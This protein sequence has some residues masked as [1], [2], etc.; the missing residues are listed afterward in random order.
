MYL[1]GGE[2]GGSTH[3]LTLE[4]TSF[5]STVRA[6]RGRP[7]SDSMASEETSSSGTNSVASGE[8]P[9]SGS[10]SVASGSDS[11]ASEETSSSSTVGGRVESD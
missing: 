8:T 10:D 9:S 1:L 4:R 3:S 5:S 11:I 7:E 6:P 2:D